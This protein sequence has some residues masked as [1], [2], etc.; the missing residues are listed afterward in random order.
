MHPKGPDLDD[1]D[2]DLA[3]DPLLRRINRKLESIDERGDLR[4]GLVLVPAAIA[5]V[6]L[7]MMNIKS[8][9]LDMLE[10]AVVIG[11]I[12]GT[13][14]SAVRQK[15]RVAVRHGLVCQACGYRPPVFRILSAA[16]TERCSK[17]NAPLRVVR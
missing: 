5:A 15:R 11:A 14:F 13:I 4:L 8:V 16:M 7:Q 9:W 6:A 10:V 1:E 2:G 3:D 12:G 17:C